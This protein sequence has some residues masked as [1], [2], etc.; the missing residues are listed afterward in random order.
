[1]EGVS[2]LTLL[3][4]IGSF[5]SASHVPD[6]ILEHTKMAFANWLAVTIHGA[7]TTEGQKLVAFAQ[8]FGSGKSLLVGTNIHSPPQIAA[9]VNS[10]N[11]HIDDYDDTHLQTVTHPSTPVIGAV[12]S[13]I[14]KNTTVRDFLEG[15]ALGSE[16][17]IRVALLLGSSH[18]NRGWHSTA[19]TGVIGAA[20][21]AARLLSLDAEKIVY[22]GGLATLQPIGLRTA[23]GTMGKAFQVGAA[24]ES[25]YISAKGS[26]FGLDA[27]RDALENRVGL[28]IISTDFDPG[29]LSTLG[30]EWHFLDDIF[31][32][33]P[34]GIVAHPL[35]DAGR[36]LFKDCSKRGKIERIIATV[37]PLVIDLTGISRPHTGL[38]IKF[39]SSYLLALAI[40]KGNVTIR[41]MESPSSQ[42]ILELSDR[43]ELVPDT[44]VAT[45]SCNLEVIFPSNETVATSV[46]GIASGTAE[47]EW[48]KLKEK[49]ENCVDP[50]LKDSSS[51]WKDW[52]RID[53]DSPI[54]DFIRSMKI[55]TN[56]RVQ[57]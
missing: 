9:L 22:A 4:S 47:E 54:L 33:Y 51:V 11:G 10:A 8:D 40:V 14:E 20:V 15:I 45:D 46:K 37:N 25:G 35:I 34:C 53:M 6:E 7:Q 3:E 12:L 18:Y 41:N 56:T 16:I 48:N 52:T 39:S 23:F 28:R 57:A 30:S 32:S 5:A 55:E 2:K 43:V 13:C 29:Q 38:E 27:P 49:F 31:K 24:S 44:N 21:G 17:G 36:S 42:E 26:Q 50:W 1:M 19:T